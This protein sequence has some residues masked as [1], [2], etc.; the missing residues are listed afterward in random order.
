MAVAKI[1]AHLKRFL[2]AVM[3]ELSLPAY[4]LLTSS[5]NIFIDYFL[6]ITFDSAENT[7]NFIDL[8]IFSVAADFIIYKNTVRCLENFYS[9]LC[10]LVIR[11]GIIQN[12]NS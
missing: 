12:I 10:F 6:P 2:P 8:K 1:L 11:S 9:K 5:E 3:S 7:I 4:L